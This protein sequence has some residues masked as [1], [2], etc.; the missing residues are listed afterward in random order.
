[1]GR[2]GTDSIDIPEFASVETER[3]DAIPLEYRYNTGF[4]GA[5]LV[6]AV[7]LLLGLFVF[8]GTL[9]LMLA[10]VSLPALLLGVLGIMADPSGV[11]RSAGKRLVIDDDLI[12]E[13]DEKGRLGWTIARRQIMDVREVSGRRVFPI[14]A[15]GWKVES[16]DIVLDDQ[17]VIRIP[18]WLLP[19]RGRR[20]K[21]R[22]RT[23]LQGSGRFCGAGQE[24]DSD[25]PASIIT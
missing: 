17:H 25:V 3:K 11:V 18:V 6:G 7:L 9:A 8:G 10:A 12:R 1:M 20:F 16:L 4:L 2:V 14:V 21:Q 23:F 24:L 19:G 13:V 22:L 15:A 5:L